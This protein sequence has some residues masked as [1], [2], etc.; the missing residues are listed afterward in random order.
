V[1]SSETVNSPIGLGDEKRLKGRRAAV[2]GAAGFIGGAVCRRLVAAGAE[3]TGLDVAED[4]ASRVRESGASFALSD[5]ADRESVRAALEGAELVVHAA[6]LVHEWGEMEEFV[7][8]NVGGTAN[9]CD[10]A[11]EVGAERV[12]HL[13]SVVV[14]GYHHGA[15]QDETAFRRSYGIPYIDT[16]SASD[17]LAARR[18]AVVIRPGDVYGPGGTQ[19]IVRPLEMARAGQLAV[20][21]KGEGVMLPIFV[22]DLVEAILLGLERGEPGEAYTVWDE[23]NPVSF[24]QHFNRIAA[25]VGAREA[26]RLP[27]P[28]LAAVGA[29]MERVAAARGSPPTITARALTFIERRG[30]VST[31]KAREGLGWKPLVPYEEGMRRTEQWLRAEG[32]I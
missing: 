27:R 7:R 1:G 20:P 24:E 15:E 23:E 12:V 19:W 3:V 22:E 16:K 2:T 28:L 29:A 32:L 26:R 31:A 13:S 25:M 21:G 9:V 6:A 11:A 4:Q 17:R 8:V 30:T 18:G 10:A 5:I 14:Y